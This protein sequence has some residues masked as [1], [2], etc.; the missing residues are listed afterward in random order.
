MNN[1]LLFGTAY[2]YEYLPCDRMEKD[3]RM[4]TEADINT[5]RIAESTWSTWEPRD[6]MFDFTYLRRV[7]D[8]AEDHGLSVIIG[9]PTYAIP[10]WLAKKYPDILA[11]THDGPGRYGHRQIFDLTHPGYRFH[12]E[13]IIRKMMAAVQPYACVIGFQLDNETHPYDTC[14]PRA[15]E[16]FAGWLKEHFKTTKALNQEMGLAYWSNSIDD[17]DDLPDVRGTINASFGAEYE[18]F[19]RDLVTKFLS[20]QRKIVDE[21]RRPDQFV[22][23][24]FDYE[25]RLSSFGLHPEVNQFDAASA[26]TIA[27]CDIYH[28][29]EHAL[30]GAEIAFGGAI[31]YALKQSNYLVLE[32]QAQ[33]NF[34]W[35][36]YPGQLRLQAFAHLASGADGVSYWHWHSIHNAIESYWKGILSHDFS[37]GA[38][39]QEAALIGREMKRLSPRLIHLTKKNRTAIMVSSR[40]QTGLKWF[41]T[42]QQG[43]VPDHNYSDYLRWICDACYRLN[44]E[45]DIIND[46]CRDFEKYDVL[47]LPV[48]Y[49]AEESL[50]ESIRSYVQNGGHVIATF[51]SFFADKYLKIYHDAQPHGM[52]DCFGLTY[53]RFTRPV[54]VSL[55]FEASRQPEDALLNDF[56]SR[57]SE[58]ALLYAHT[59]L[60][61]S[62]DPDSADSNGAFTEFHPVRDWMELLQTGSAEILCTYEH[63]AWGKLPAVTKNHFGKGQAVYLGCCFDDAGLEALL[64]GLYHSWNL[65]VSAYH[66]PVIIRQGI[67]QQDRQIIYYMNFSDMEQKLENHPGGTELF[68][69]K[70][71]SGNH[72]LVLPP[73]DVKIL[74]VQE[75]PGI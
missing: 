54:N 66:F 16:C 33:G 64:S 4:M 26:V 56:T 23:H 22:T 12:C 67:N 21:Y 10:S 47:I 58:D 29:S 72:V 25:W 75:N 27:G 41:P 73:W 13:R 2:Y 32:T 60:R 43:D 17:W 3:F 34:G 46:S 5:I 57:Q 18:A 30:T 70:Y 59:F 31:A 28:P 51:K 37:A 20:W 38:V 11:E 48:L 55:H 24:N 49:S 6:G 39:Y 71:L 61:P 14:S 15:Q 35:L 63:P 1:H 65:P 42:C 9:T 50:I 44:I 19:Q 8:A 74:E 52:T 69:G 53:D 40:S 36:P 68:S 45:Y 62:D 7:L